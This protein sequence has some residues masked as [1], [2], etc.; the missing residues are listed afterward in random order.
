MPLQSQALGATVA[1]VTAQPSK[2]VGVDFVIVVVVVVAA[3]GL[4]ALGVG[5]GD[6]L[7]LS[8]G[9]EGAGGWLYGLNDPPP[10]GVRPSCASMPSVRTG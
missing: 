3:P 2:E 6:A 10:W 4:K 5:G 9:Q 1:E 8:S 7:G